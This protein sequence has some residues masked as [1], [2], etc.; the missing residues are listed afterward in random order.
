MTGRPTAFGGHPDAVDSVANSMAAPV[1]PPRSRRSLGSWTW[2]IVFLGGVVYF[3]LPL[4][5]TLNFSLKSQPF[6]SAYTAIFDDPK[7][8]SSLV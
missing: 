7:F 8:V 6:L 2:W 1:A 3:I 4:I 5:G